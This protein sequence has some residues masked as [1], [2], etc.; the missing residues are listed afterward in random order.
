MLSEFTHILVNVA[1]GMLMGALVGLSIELSVAD[2]VE[3]IQKNGGLRHKR[4]QQQQR[5]EHW[6]SGVIQT[7]NIAIVGALATGPIEFRWLYFLLSLAGSF[8]LALL[9]FEL[10]RRKKLRIRASFLFD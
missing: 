8:F 9:L 4:D 7:L 6:L 2:S 3:S 5:G 1:C 10:G